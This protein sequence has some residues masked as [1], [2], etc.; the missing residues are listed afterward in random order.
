MVIAKLLIIS[1]ILCG[2]VLH[3]TNEATP[4]GRWGLAF[5]G[6]ALLTLGVLLW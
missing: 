6:G 1:A 2:I 3:M 5:A 4:A